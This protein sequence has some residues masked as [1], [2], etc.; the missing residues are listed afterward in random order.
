MTNEIRNKVLITLRENFTTEQLHMIDMAIAK[1][2]VGYRIEKEETLPAIVGDEIPAEIKEFLIRKEL[3]GCS[4]GTYVQYEYILKNFAF[5]INKNIR[6]VKDTDVLAYLDYRM[7]SCGVSARTANGNRLILSSFFTYMHDT[8]K[9]SYNPMKTVD[10]IKFKAKVREPLSDIELERVRNACQTLRE[11]A[12]FEVL[13]STGARV[14]E[15]VGLD[16][17]NIDISSRSAIITG[18]GDQERHIFLN[19]KSLLAIDNYIKSRNDNQSA[20]FVGDVSPHKRLSKA[21]IESIIRDIGKRAG[22]NRPLFP[23]LLRHT[24]ATDMLAQGAKIDEVSEML[25][26]KKLE[27]TKIYAKT[28]KASLETAHRRFA[29]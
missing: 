29:A 24:F 14:S 7:N 9:M 18:K 16:Y 27:T 15:I 4:A 10:P 6:E 13:Y 17:T 12:L 1:A 11:K 19:A 2:L 28:S 5:R 20:L 8:G 3:K 22:L 26:H 21:S 25:G 23:H